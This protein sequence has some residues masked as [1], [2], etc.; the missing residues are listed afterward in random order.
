MLLLG[1]SE[2]FLLSV[3]KESKLIGWQKLLFRCCGR[4][5]KQNCAGIRKQKKGMMVVCDAGEK[6]AEG[7]G[8]QGRYKAHLQGEF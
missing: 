2:S 7:F 4:R 8:V 1:K 3:E 5:D 6:Y